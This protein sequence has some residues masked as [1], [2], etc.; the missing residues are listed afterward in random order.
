[1]H[2]LNIDVTL[3][4]RLEEQVDSYDIFSGVFVLSRCFLDFSVGKVV[5]S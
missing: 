1:M 3:K 5:L 2:N 4:K